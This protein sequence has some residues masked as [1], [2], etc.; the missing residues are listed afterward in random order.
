[1]KIEAGI[2]EMGWVVPIP[3][4]FMQSPDWL[5]SAC[6]APDGQVYSAAAMVGNEPLVGLR[7]AHDGVPIIVDEGHIYL[8]VAWLAKEF[9][10]WAE[11]ME[12]IEK[13]VR[14]T[15]AMDPAHN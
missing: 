14:E 4:S 7:A 5:M 11:V 12:A 9:P 15:I 13:R 1:M 6:L 8:P 2:I 3:G 10:E